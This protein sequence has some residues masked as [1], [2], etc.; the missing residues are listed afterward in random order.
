MFRFFRLATCCLLAPS[1][2]G[3]WTNTDKPVEPPNAWEEPRKYAQWMYNR[4]MDGWNNTTFGNLF[5]STEYLAGWSST[6]WDGWVWTLLDSIVSTLGW[7]VFG[8][9]WTQ[10]RSGFALLIRVGIFLAIC[11]V[12][13]DLFA[14]CWPIVSIVVG[15]AVTFIWMGRTTLKWSCTPC[16]DSVAEF[17]R[18]QTLFSLVQELERHPKPRPCGS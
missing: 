4:T 15:I 6:S 17:Q 9:A 11:I 3:W 16:S 18:R 1:I 5:D 8:K 2:S 12:I 14:M 13:H 7:L 10:V